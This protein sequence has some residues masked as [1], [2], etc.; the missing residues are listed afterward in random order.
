MSPHPPTSVP[1]HPVERTL[2]ENVHTAAVMERDDADGGV[3]THAIPA[4]TTGRGGGGDDL[5]LPEE[6]EEFSGTSSQLSLSPGTPPR[7]RTSPSH[8]ERRQRWVPTETPPCR[9]R[10]S[11]GGSASP[12]QCHHRRDRRTADTSESTA[13][14]RQAGGIADTDTARNVLTVPLREA[15]AAPEPGSV[16][17]KAPIAVPTRAAEVHPVPSLFSSACLAAAS[18]GAADSCGDSRAASIAAA[19][20]P[21]S[22]SLLSSSRRPTLFQRTSSEPNEE[23]YEAHCIPLDSVAEASVGAG[24]EG[25]VYAVDAYGRRLDRPSQERQE[26]GTD[27]DVDEE[28]Y[29]TATAAGVV[30]MS[31]D[32]RFERNRGRHVAAGMRE[33]DNDRGQ[34]EELRAGEAAERAAAAAATAA[35]VCEARAARDEAKRLRAEA[36]E[37]SR[38][39]EAVL[40]LRDVLEIAHQGDGEGTINGDAR[41]RATEHGRLVL[42]WRAASHDIR[43]VFVGCV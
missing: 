6:H 35:A 30:Q 13:R 21:T 41:E 5:V 39:R 17:V 37:L 27:P 23:R 16:L 31:D 4:T 33:N 10:T 40:D 9:H 29:K 32:D 34:R 11:S 20:A 36:V 24:G 28:S 7:L 1:L 12:Q 14:L 18:G 2:Y 15:D 26:Q 19:T 22:S 42:K 3:C 8:P 43:P 25:S 38:W